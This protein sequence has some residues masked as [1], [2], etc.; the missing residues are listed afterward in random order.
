M[1]TCFGFIRYIRAPSPPKI[2]QPLLWQQLATSRLEAL[3]RRCRNLS[4]CKKDVR[5]CLMFNAPSFMQKVH[6]IVSPVS[7][8]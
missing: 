8:T 3:W 1:T 6:Y 7:A 5:T 2:L 4:M